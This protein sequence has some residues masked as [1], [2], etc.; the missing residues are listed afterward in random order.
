VPSGTLVLTK[1]LAYL[2]CKLEAIFRWQVRKRLISYVTQMW[3]VSH[4]FTNGYAGNWGTW[5]SIHRHCKHMWWFQFLHGTQPVPSR[6]IFMCN[7]SRRPADVT[8]RHVPFLHPADNNKVICIR[9]RRLR[10]VYALMILFNDALRQNM[11]NRIIV[12]AEKYPFLILVS[13]IILIGKYLQQKQIN[14]L[15]NS[16]NY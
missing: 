10:N 13:L 11:P 1:T 7:F 3:L 14:F 16:Q 5:N 15:I 12:S 4:M 9:G 2:L 8:C 6:L